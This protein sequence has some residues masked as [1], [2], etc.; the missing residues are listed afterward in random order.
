MRDFLTKPAPRNPQMEWII[1]GNV[2]NFDNL[3]NG[4]QVL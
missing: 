4:P 1:Q 2:L 3:V